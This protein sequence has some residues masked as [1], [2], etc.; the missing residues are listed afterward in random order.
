MLA[1]CIRSAGF[2][3]SRAIEDKVL[4]QAQVMVAH[5]EQFVADRTPVDIGMPLVRWLP[6]L[7]NY[8]VCS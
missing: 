4:E 1:S 8:V 3:S 2:G 5:L 6:M 7:N